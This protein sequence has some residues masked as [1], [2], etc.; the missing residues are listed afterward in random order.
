M[1]PEVPDASIAVDFPEHVYFQQEG[2][3]I[4]LW[5]EDLSLTMERPP[6]FDDSRRSR[7]ETG[8]HQDASSSELWMCFLHVVSIVASPIPNF[9]TAR[10]RFKMHITSHIGPRPI[11]LGI[12]IPLPADRHRL[13]ASRG[14]RSSFSKNPRAR[15]ATCSLVRPAPAQRR[16]KAGR[17]S[18]SRPRGCSPYTQA[19]P[20][21]RSL[22]LVLHQVQFLQE[23]IDAYPSA[24]P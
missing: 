6:Q 24:L 9:A 1:E 10:S 11:V 16:V 19:L 3:T 14:F 8:R 22:A 13:C 17:S 18:R 21:V 4:L 23:D 2:V 15:P 12:P 5:S 7:A 20:N